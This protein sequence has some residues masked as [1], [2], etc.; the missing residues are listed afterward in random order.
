MSKYNLERVAIVGID[1]SECGDEAL[2]RGLEWL[3]AEATRT[4]HLVHVVDP[5][6][7]I[8]DPDKP[9]LETEADALA[10]AP[11]TMRERAK[12][13]CQMAGL[14]L[15][16]ARDG[17]R[18]RTHARIGQP[19]EALLQAS[20][21]YEADLLLVGTHGRRGMERL[22]LGSVAE[23][24]VRRARCPVLVMRRKNYAGCPKTPRPDAPYRPGEHRP[25]AHFASR[26]EQITSTESDGWHPSDAG[27]TGIRIV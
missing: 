1:F 22:L 26:H 19:V 25:D 2:I 5:R 8:E 17:L 11:I 14:D 16:L 20:V 4:L 12:V 27:P 15:Q 6:L 7:V 9:A 18:L 24:L 23:L 13:L 3:A 10:Q 21:D